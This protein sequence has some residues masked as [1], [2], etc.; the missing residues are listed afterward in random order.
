MKMKKLIALIL[1]GVMMIALAG[2]QESTET[3]PV[4]QEGSSGQDVQE[5]DT[6][7]ATAAQ[8]A[9]GSSTEAA[10][11]E[12]A[13]KASA[14]VTESGEAQTPQETTA[15]PEKKP[16]AMVMACGELSGVFNS[17]FATHEGDKAVAKLVMPSILMMDR[18]GSLVYNAGEGETRSTARGEYV[19]N[20]V[21]SVAEAY[22]AE[23][24]ATAYTITVREG[25]LFSDG[26]PITA[27]D[28]IF[29]YYVLCDPAY[30]G[31]SKVQY[32]NI[33]GVRAYQ[34]NNTA[35]PGIEVTN[36]DVNDALANP[37]EGLRQAV[38]DQ[39]I[40][41]TLEEERDWCRENWQRYVDRGYGNS[42]EE[43]FVTLYTSTL[44][45]GYKAGDKSFDQIV[46][47]TVSLFGMN[48][49][50]LAKNYK[51]DIDYFN[52]TVKTITRN[53]IYQTLLEKA[54]GQEMPRISGISKVDD[55]TVSVRILGK[56]STAIRTI[57]DIPILS[58]HYY[59][60][61]DLYDYENDQ[62]GLVR[63]ELESIRARDS[64]PFGYGPY[65]L[66]SSDGTAVTLTRNGYYYGA[67]PEDASLKLIWSDTSEMLGLLTEGRADIA[68]LPLTDTEIAAIRDTNENGSLNG[69]K[70][71][72][73]TY[74][75][76]TYYYF[77]MNAT[78]VN[79]DDGELTE[80][81]LHLRRAIGMVICS[82]RAD[83]CGKYYG[84]TAK[85][86]NYPCS[87]SFY[88]MPAGSGAAG[89]SFVK[90]AEGTPLTKDNVMDAVREE[91]TAAGY[92]FKEEG[93]ISHLPEG[94]KLAFKVMVPPYLAGDNAVTA[95]LAEAKTMLESIGFE[96]TF[97][98][99]TD[100]NEF[101]LALANGKAD[102]W[103]ARRSAS[104]VLSPAAFYT[105]SGSSNYYNLHDSSI[106]EMVKE[107][108]DA[109]GQEAKA[110]VYA[111]LFEKIMQDAVEVPI[112]QKQKG[113]VYNAEK[114][115]IDPNT[116]LTEYCS[117]LDDLS[118]VRLLENVPEEER[119]TE[120][121][122][123]EE[124]TTEP[125]TTE[126]PAAEPEPTESETDGTAED[127]TESAA[128]EEGASETAEEPASSEEE[129]STMEDGGTTTQE[130]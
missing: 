49:K 58:L 69:D 25:A 26:T 105:S 29:T 104:A 82:L 48:Y 84:E 80:A 110:A 59:G 38:V 78:R 41:P 109:E 71:R 93:N 24:N 127:G 57:C 92:T 53:Y 97:K 87:T 16:G 3:L 103:V 64:A 37:T 119:V 55:R 86:I 7:A 11:T 108:A 102:M 116:E 117:V 83:A 91:L 73:V 70:L 67:E 10:A 45:P 98:E 114:I 22:D 111:R 2:C 4:E 30:D 39:V 47:D 9:A 31:P 130:D 122:T 125:P 50:T 63:G 89:T 75:D 44:S 60:N 123:Q 36:S 100:V 121:T 126:P 8:T 15:A 51:N 77:G 72:T 115:Y 6:E 32:Q 128:S 113:I 129:P 96:I 65:Q 56:S 107:L 40:R 23:N 14:P 81:S 76:D 43:L 74:N 27:D 62:F 106:N 61:E 17:L 66:L 28:V 35:A 85:L 1:S 5:T 79:V 112:Y 88:A 99:Y 19:Y 101:V 90:D 20:G 95:I 33:F 18:Q 118:V 120:T 68:D 94:G 34:L 42:A 46:E 13:T 54:G 52:E 12:G 21:A 124:T